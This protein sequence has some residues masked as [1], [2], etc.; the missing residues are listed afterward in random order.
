MRQQMQGE[1]VFPDEAQSKGC[2]EVVQHEV[3]CALNED[4]NQRPFQCMQEWKKEL[5]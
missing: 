3:F 4:N 5:L 1:E 2:L